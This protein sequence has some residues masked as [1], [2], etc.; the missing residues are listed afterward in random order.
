MMAEKFESRILL[1]G[2]VCEAD[3]RNALYS[4]LR[5]GGK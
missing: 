4:H 2:K 3:G 5:P 1:D